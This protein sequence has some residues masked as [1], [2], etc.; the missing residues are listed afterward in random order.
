MKI[1]SSEEWETLLTSA[2]REAVHLEMRDRYAVDDESD[3]FARWLAG[4]P[5]SPAE[6]AEWWSDWTD[7]V[8]R[9]TASGVTMRR[10]RIV[11]EPVTDYIRYEWAGTH[12]NVDAGED[13]RWL[14]R[15]HASTIALPGN[16]FW[17]I[18][19]EKVV[20]NHF[21]GDGEWLGN[22]LTDDPAVVQLC[23]AA[24]GAVWAA[25]IPHSEYKPA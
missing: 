15:R 6:E 10:A 9:I 8:G 4:N 19:G 13:V 5:M 3:P 2:H 22:E 25:A 16:D 24:F 20:F 23:A 12:Y 21:T 17:L 11:S 1:L 7:L 18:D 14:P